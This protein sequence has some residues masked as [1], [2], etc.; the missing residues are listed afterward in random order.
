MKVKRATENV[1]RKTRLVSCDLIARTSA[2]MPF[3]GPTAYSLSPGI[4][5]VR[6][7]G[8][9]HHG[10]YERFDPYCFETVPRLLIQLLHAV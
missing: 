6:R 2:Q 7:N 8:L 1:P 5:Y 4:G 10:R 3:T 9:A